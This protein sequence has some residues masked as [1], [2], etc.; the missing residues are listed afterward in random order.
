MGR[1]RTRVGRAGVSPSSKKAVDLLAGS[2]AGRRDC[3][4]Q[5]KEPFGATPSLHF[6]RRMK[7]SI[8]PPCARSRSQPFEPHRHAGDRSE[9]T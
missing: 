7:P 3:Q 2:F 8:K 5:P 9:C 4:R 1:W 6:V